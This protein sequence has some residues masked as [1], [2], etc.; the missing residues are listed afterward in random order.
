M[1]CT[2]GAAHGAVTHSCHPGKFKLAGLY[3][4]ALSWGQL[5]RKPSQCTVA[6]NKL[7][8]CCWCTVPWVRLAIAR[9]RLLQQLTCWSQLPMGGVRSVF[10]WEQHSIP[11]AGKPQ[12]IHTVFTDSTVSSR[13]YLFPSPSP[14]LV[15]RPAL[16]WSNIAVRSRKGRLAS[17]SACVS[18]KQTHTTLAAG[19]PTHTVHTHLRIPALP[20]KH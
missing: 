1:Q 3:E 6:C 15:G 7:T 13:H 14:S 2:W 12:H 19:F 17:S 10:P 16:L 20:A 8:V 18:Y 9:A 5:S 11:A 4:S